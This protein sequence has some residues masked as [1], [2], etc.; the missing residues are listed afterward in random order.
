MIGYVIGNYKITQKLGEGGMG[1]VFKGIDLMLEREVAIKMLRPELARQQAIVE[2]FRA[3]AV[4]LAKLNHPNIATLYNF[5]RQGHD[6]FMIM[7]YVKGS[8]FENIIKKSG[9]IPPQRA[10]QLFAQALEGIAHAHRLGIIHRDLKPANVMLMDSGLIKVMDFGIARVLGSNRL[11]RTGNVIG[12]MEYMSPEQIRGE[13]TDARS[14]IYSAGILLYEML[15][16]RVPFESNSEYELMRRQVEDAP[17]PPR[18]F[19]QQIPLQVEQAIMRSLAKKPSARFQSADEFRAV[20]LKGVDEATAVLAKPPAAK[21]QPSG[22]LLSSTPLAAG[23]PTPEKK[24]AA[25][26]KMPDTLDFSSEPPQAVKERRLPD[27]SEAILK[28]TRLA[29]DGQ[30]DVQAEARL[31]ET[32]FANHQEMQRLSA[33]NQQAAPLPQPSLNRP[34]TAPQNLWF[35]AFINRLNWRHYA[36]VIL[37]ALLS[38]PI[39]FLASSNNPSQANANQALPKK[40]LASLPEP[41]REASAQSPAAASNP[42]T[43]PVEPPPPPVEDQTPVQAPETVSQEKPAE[44]RR[45]GRKT[46]QVSARQPAPAREPARPKEDSNTE[47]REEKKKEKKGGL[48]DK[49]KGGLKKI[50]PFK[51]D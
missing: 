33:A 8:T 49:V 13:D 5:V 10:L 31:K 19:S 29:N 24:Q 27:A 4:T 34:Q 50:N 3:E 37:L 23:Q 48:F 25:P 2:R 45:A 32:R 40:N 30:P 44:N 18:N 16:G 47:N 43:A 15:T 1:D 26:K 36:A 6:L 11:T 7:E 17:L 51:K 41:K 39:A 22:Q 20:L 12:T 28:E 9:A 42:R 46:R 14:D 21:L 35:A 38:I